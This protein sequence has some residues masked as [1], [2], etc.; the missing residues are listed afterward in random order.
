MHVRDRRRKRAVATSSDG[1]SSAS[2]WPTSTPARSCPGGPSPCRAPRAPRAA[3]G[4]SRDSASAAGGASP[5]AALPRLPAGRCGWCGSRRRRRPGRARR[6]APARPV[7]RPLAVPKKDGL[8]ASG[9]TFCGQCVMVCPT[10]ALTAPGEAGSR[11]L[12]GWRKRTGLLAARA[13]ARS[14]AAAHR[15]RVGDR[16]RGPGVFLLADVTGQV[17][18]IGGV[19]DLSRGIALGAGRAGLRRR[20][21]LPDRAGPALHPAGERASRPLRAGA[22]T[23]AS[24]ERPR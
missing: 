2:W 1:V 4:G 15:G 24:R 9:C 19:A 7:A 6:L 18:R 12:E 16:P 21:L 11:W 8:R 20:L 14:L 5:S 13:A 17:L 22:G 3:S 10:G 23:S